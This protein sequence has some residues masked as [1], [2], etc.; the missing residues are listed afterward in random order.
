MFLV[1]GSCGGYIVRIRDGVI[2]GVF[3]GRVL[4]RFRFFVRY[5]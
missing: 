1:A 3:G 5:L 4:E 2:R